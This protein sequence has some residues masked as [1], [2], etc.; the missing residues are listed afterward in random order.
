MASDSK[1]DFTRTY[2]TMRK[3]FYRGTFNYKNDKEIDRLLSSAFDQI[4]SAAKLSDAD[5]SIFELD[6]LI[7]DKRID[8]A[9]KYYPKVEPVILG[10]M[11]KSFTEY[12][13]AWRIWTDL[14]TL[15]MPGHDEVF[16]G[17]GLHWS[18][19]IW[20]L[21]QCSSQK[22]IGVLLE[23]LQKYGMALSAPE[24]FKFHAATYSDD[25]LYSLAMLLISRNG[26]TVNDR[27][28]ISKAILTGNI[29]KTSD[30]RKCFD[31]I[32][33]LLPQDAC[34]SAV[35]SAHTCMW[36]IC[37]LLIDTMLMFEKR[38][39]TL[40][41]R[42]DD[43]LKVH[44]SDVEEY[45]YRRGY[46]KQNNVL[47]AKPKVADAFQQSADYFKIEPLSHGFSVVGPGLYG[48]EIS[49]E[50]L[51]NLDEMKDIVMLQK[52][53]MRPF[54]Y[55]L[56]DRPMEWD[57]AYAALCDGKYKKLFPHPDLKIKC[58]CTNLYKI[59]FGLFRMFDTGDDM[60]F[61]YP[62]GYALTVYIGLHMPWNIDRDHKRKNV[63]KHISDKPATVFTE[64]FDD[65]VYRSLDG[66]QLYSINQLLYLVS[67]V[68]PPINKNRYIAAY[69]RLSAFDMPENERIAIALAG[70]LANECTY[71]RCK[72]DLHMPDDESDDL[73][74]AT[75]KYIDLSQKSK[76][77]KRKI[78]SLKCE[79]SKEKEY[80]QNLEV[81]LKELTQKH[82]ELKAELQATQEMVD[83]LNSDEEIETDP[84]ITFP[85]I[86]EH[87]YV[88]FGGY[89]K[90][91]QY[92]KQLIIGDVSFDIAESSKVTREYIRSADVVAIFVRFISHP[93]YWAI[94][95]EAKKYNKPVVYLNSKNEKLC[96]TKIV[97]KDIQL[98]EAE[99]G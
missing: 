86:L 1:K 51:D 58:D 12:S 14:N 19:A 70:G 9:K 38:I 17:Y 18:A 94:I 75:K 27:V 23:I 3:D 8:A 80:T 42:H 76:E 67:S 39:V 5:T 33:S 36:Q 22:K 63:K 84:H 74:T 99:I 66:K 50:I 81:Q 20:I 45:G 98:L 49:E 87:K 43:L 96:A 53:V 46:L 72:S 25:I 13:S 7:V 91:V 82:E 69:Q 48:S 52:D 32:M 68:V 95:Q 31:E 60:I 92:M 44:I 28:L 65:C 64:N 34:E 77:R 56:C 93:A 57:E 10:K 61:L 85:Y 26:T 89:D 29:D 21:S 71:T 73:E 90:W 41:K 16:S 59:A 54:S 30:A 78:D 2:N 4:S 37:D 83:V 35:D 15:Y 79:L 97:E 40:R 6:H 62:L 55:L 47:S 11:P 88:I 24:T